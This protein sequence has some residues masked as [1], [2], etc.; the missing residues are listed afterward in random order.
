MVVEELEFIYKEEVCA[1]I[2]QIALK[3]KKV[4]IGWGDDMDMTME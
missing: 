1:A 4:K 3:F 2:P